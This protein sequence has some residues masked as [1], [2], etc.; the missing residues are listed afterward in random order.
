MK[1]SGIQFTSIFVLLLSFSSAQEFSGYFTDPAYPGKCFFGGVAVS[2]GN[3]IQLSGKCKLFICTTKDGLGK[4][5]SCGPQKVDSP[6]KLGDFLNANAS[7]PSCCRRE[8]ICP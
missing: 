5:R 7:F 1:L 8:I 6:C 3:E 4:V 2:P